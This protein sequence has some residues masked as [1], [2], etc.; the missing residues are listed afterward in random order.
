MRRV[1]QSRRQRGAVLLLALVLICLL[2]VI[3][4]A[5]TAVVLRDTR[6]MAEQTAADIAALATAQQMAAAAQSIAFQNAA[7]IQTYF[8]DALLEP[9]REAGLAEELAARDVIGALQQEVVTQVYENPNVIRFAE[10]PAETERSEL[11]VS[12]ME[13]PIAMQRP[14]GGGQIA[15]TTVVSTSAEGRAPAPRYVRDFNPLVRRV[16]RSVPNHLLEEVEFA[17]R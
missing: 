10:L 1:D 14:G 9:S 12:G 16:A 13:A 17:E 7:A 5:V 11:V 4:L 2:V 8:D 6:Q 3:V 15:V